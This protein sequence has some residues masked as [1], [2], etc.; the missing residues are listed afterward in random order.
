MCCSPK[1]C[2]PKPLLSSNVESTSG[3]M[4]SAEYS[5][6]VHRANESYE[7][8]QEELIKYRKTHKNAISVNH[9]KPVKLSLREKMKVFFSQNSPSPQLESK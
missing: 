2:T 8:R 6:M 7:R 9:K 3:N 1:G 5:D 4:S